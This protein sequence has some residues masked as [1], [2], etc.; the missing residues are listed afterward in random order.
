MTDP[1]E[2]RREKPEVIESDDIIKPGDVSRVETPGDILRIKA[3][4]CI[5]GAALLIGVGFLT[6][7]LQM[8]DTDL[9]SWATGLISLVVGAAIGFVFSG[10]SQR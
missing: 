7:A 9:K 4:A 3:A 5:A 10:S 1:D 2:K 6:A 8:N